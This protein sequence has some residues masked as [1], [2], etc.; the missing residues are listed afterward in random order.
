[1]NPLIRWPL[2]VVLA[3]AL[4]ASGCTCGNAVNV[5]GRAPDAGGGPSG[6]GG[7]GVVA[8]GG[9][10]GGGSAGGSSAGGDPTG[11]G[12]GGDAVDGGEDGGST[13]LCSL[14]SCTSANANCGPVGDGCGGFISCGTCT[15]PETCG[16]GG[17]P[18]RCGGSMGCIPR[19]CASQ[20][21]TC[22]PLSDGCGGIV[23]CGACTG[24]GESCGG[25][26]TP[27]RCGVAGTNLV[28]GGCVPRTQCPVGLNC[29]PIADGCG[30]TLSCGT[31]T[32][33]GQSC[34]G[35]GVA[36]VCGTTNTC[37]PRT[38]QQ[39]G[40]TCGQVGDGC[41]G[42]TP[43]C[44][45]CPADAGIIC[46]GG[47]I[48]NVCG[49]NVPDGGLCTNLCQQQ[50]RCDAGVNTVTGTVRAP[51]PPAYLAPGQQADPIPGAL[52]YVPNGTVQPLPQGVS[53]TTCAGQAS[54]SP[55]VTATTG[56]DGTFTLSNVPCGANIPLVIQLGKWRRQVTLPSVACCGNTALTAEQTRLPRTQSEGDLPLIA[57]VTGN[58]DPMECILPKVGIAPSEFSLPSGNG[59][60]RFFRDNGTNFSGGAPGEGSLFGNPSELAKYDLVIV[61]CVGSP[62]AQDATR[63]ANLRTY[64][65]SGGRLYVSHYGYVWLHT[66]SPFNSVASWA[67][68]TNPPDQLAFIDTSF[69]KGAT[70][71]QWMQLTGGSPAGQ[72][73]R[74]NVQ[75]V[76]RDTNGLPAS[77]PAQRWVF[78]SNPSGS[79]AIPLQ[80]T[81]N[82]PVGVPAAQQCG[83][84]LFSDFHV[85]T[86]G[87]GGGTFPSSCGSAS[88]MSAQ[89]KVLEFM[90]FDLTS[91]IQ[92]DSGGPVCAP[93]T[94]QQLGFSCGQQG[95]GCGGVVNCGSCPAGQFCGGA[96]TPGVCG[97]TSCTPRTCQAQS[98]ECGQAGDGC[99]N[100][101]QCGSCPPGQVCG[102]AGPGRCGSGGCTPRTCQQ[103]GLFCGPAGDG[104]GNVIQCGPCTAPDTCGGNGMPGV[105]GRP[106]CQPRTC[107]QASAQCGLVADGCGAT[108]DC[109]P[110]PVGQTCGGAG[111]PNQCGGIM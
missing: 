101:I 75:E 31:C 26:G 48:P 11:G 110:C 42:L 49:T 45:T 34:G 66:N 93:R 92:P 38:C 103:L 1:M 85:S 60:V 15:P 91:C 108:V 39:A 35:G 27:N 33:A 69:P 59:R 23:Q 50:N 73:G 106:A 102:A 87:T 53:C 20:G 57:M 64:L 37:V 70:F 55:L 30:G 83:R 41:G 32:T 22:G 97:S 94:C 47:G 28:D 7:G 65:N 44:G 77:S 46:G 78:S 9:A 99:G 21:A 88:P 105:C 100:V 111:V 96:G 107:Q 5:G 13:Q 14:V 68:G 89:E 90:I 86:G 72:P 12:G 63:L 76:R 36:N 58:A 17:T 51:T 80:F 81:F 6:T 98:L 84:V 29:G 24:P 82:T 25:G 71:S 61:D 3:S 74:M 16:G 54:G 95:D 79:G 56:T 19:T 10:A 40:A 18:S 67:V 4:V 52:V 8:G 43:N 104:C 62:V 2:G 109:G